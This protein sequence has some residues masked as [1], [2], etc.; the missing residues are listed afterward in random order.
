MERG[1]QKGKRKG[2]RISEKGKQVE[3]DSRHIIEKEQSYGTG[4]SK[5]KGRQG[6]EETFRRLEGRKIA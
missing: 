3:Y 5:E 1:N 6:G 4:L 2:G